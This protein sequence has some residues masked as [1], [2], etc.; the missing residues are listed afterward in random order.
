MDP[1]GEMQ[2]MFNTD[3]NVAALTTDELL[4]RANKEISW[5]IHK[6]IPEGSLTY[7]GAPPKSFKSFIAKYMAMA[8]ASGEPL[9]GWDEFT[10][11]KGNVLYIDEENS[12]FR[13]GRR[14]RQI[15]KGL[16][17]EEGF[18]NVFWYSKN[19]LK[20]DGFGVGT[21]QELIKRH[22][23]STIILD[24]LVRFLEGDE[25][26]AT[27]VR[28]A[29]DMIK[30]IQKGTGVTVIILHHLK[31]T[32]KQ[33]NSVELNDF[34]GSGDF[35]AMADS[36]LG[37][38]KKSNGVSLQVVESRDIPS[39]DL[40]WFL[41]ITGDGETTIKIHCQGREQKE[42]TISK[43]AQ[44]LNL[45]KNKVENS[46]KEEF[47]R[48]ELLNMFSKE[49]SNHARAQAITNALGFILKKK[50]HGVYEKIKEE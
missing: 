45:L 13:L 25:D 16:A 9:L 14:V 18:E 31:K 32:T 20:L 42:Q 19:N 35:G 29:Y 24:S 47:T 11:K 49:I 5:T 7:I 36:I 43:P 12:D 17:T 27:D 8:I 41:G 40:N 23:I 26:R 46:S 22:N 34:R 48:Q 10:T 28:K 4:E 37:L 2:N 15:R 21:I 44:A 3:T 38:V 33:K 1:F 50:K 30:E 39:D 6:L